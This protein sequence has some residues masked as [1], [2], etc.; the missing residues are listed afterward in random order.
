MAV[1]RKKCV[2]WRF[3]F[4]PYPY[5]GHMAASLFSLSPASR[6][7]LPSRKGK[8][9]AVKVPKANHLRKAVVEVEDIPGPSM[10]SS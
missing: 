3:H 7:L 4:D 10:Y 6:F 2:R 1:A 5:V 8:L 9:R